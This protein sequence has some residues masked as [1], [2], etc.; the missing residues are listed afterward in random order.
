MHDHPTTV[1]CHL[2]NAAEL[3]LDAAIAPNTKS[4]YSTAIQNMLIFLDNYF[5]KAELVDFTVEK[6]E[7]ENVKASQPKPFYDPECVPS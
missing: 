2:I 1:P 6:N 3:L 4:T 7:T 5:P